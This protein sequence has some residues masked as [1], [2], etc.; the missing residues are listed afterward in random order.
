MS[1]HAD[2][3][4][5]HYPRGTTALV[6]LDLVTGTVATSHSGLQ[7]TLR[8]GIK[9][10]QGRVVLPHEGPVFLSAVYDHFFLIGYSVH[11]LSVSG[12]TGVHNTY[13]V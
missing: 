9:N 11:W 8:R 12:M 3:V 10:W 13:R 5:V 6:W 2:I 7:T 1:Q 4:A